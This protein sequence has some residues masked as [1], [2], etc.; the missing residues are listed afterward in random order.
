MFQYDVPIRCSN[1]MFQYDV[2]IRC[3]NTMFQYDVP[4]RCSNTMFQYDVPI[5]LTRDR[6]D[7]PKDTNVNFTSGDEDK[8]QKTN[9]SASWR[10]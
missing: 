8:P 4:I 1:T 9:K 10:H 7:G 2:P 5:R 3:S 6:I